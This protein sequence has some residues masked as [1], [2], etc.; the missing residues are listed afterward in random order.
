MPCLGKAGRNATVLLL[1]AVV[2]VVLRSARAIGESQ[3]DLGAAWP[4]PQGSVPGA[5]YRTDL[6]WKTSPDQST[7]RELSSARNVP[8]TGVID[9]QGVYYA[10]SQSEQGQSPYMY[11]VSL[12]GSGSQL[13]AEST[14]FRP[15]SNLVVSPVLSSEQGSSPKLLVVTASR[16]VSGASGL[17]D[18]T[19][20]YAL[21]TNATLTENT[22]RLYWSYPSA[23]SSSAVGDIRASGVPDE[24]GAIYFGVAEQD[25]T[26]VGYSGVSGVL[27]LSLATGLPAWSPP[28]IPI[29]AEG[30]SASPLVSG[31]NLLVRSGAWLYV[32]RRDSGAVIGSLDMVA[33]ASSGGLAECD[34]GTSTRKSDEL[35]SFGVADDVVMGLNKCV[36]SV[37]ISGSETGSLSI[38][39][40]RRF[41]EPIAGHIAVSYYGA[42]VAAEETGIVH[43]LDSATGKGL[44]GNSGIALS[45]PGSA[46]GSGATVVLSRGPLIIGDQSTLIVDKKNHFIWVLRHLD[47]SVKLEYPPAGAMTSEMVNVRDLPA[48]ARDGSLVFGSLEG[49]YSLGG[50]GGCAAGTSVVAGDPS[51]NICSVCPSGTYSNSLD[52]GTC[53][54]CSS[55]TWQSDERS[56]FCFIC[57]VPEWCEGGNVCA[58]ARTGTACSMCISGYFTLSD[59][60]RECPNGS[61]GYSLLFVVFCVGLVLLILRY[62]GAN[63]YVSGTKFTHELAP[64]DAVKLRVKIG[65]A[66]QTIERRVVRV[67]HDFHAILDEDVGLDVPVTGKRWKYRKKRKGGVSRWREGTGFM[68][69]PD[70]QGRLPKSTLMARAMKVFVYLVMGK[71]GHVLK[72]CRKGNADL[73]LM[74]KDHSAAL[75]DDSDSMGS[76]DSSDDENAPGDGGMKKR[77]IESATDSESEEEGPAAHADGPGVRAKREPCVKGTPTSGIQV[78]AT[79]LILGLTFFQTS[80]VVM[81]FDI[82]WPISISGFFPGIVFLSLPDLA[83]APE[84]SWSFSYAAKWFFSVT[85]PLLLLAGIYIGYCIYVER[86]PNPQVKRQLADRCVQTGLIIV[87][88]MFVFITAKS[89]EPLVCTRQADGRSYMDADPSVE[90][91]PF[92]G[93]YGLLSLAAAIFFIFWGIGTPVYLWRVLSKAKS[94]NRMGDINFIQRYGWLYLR[95]NR[96]YYWWELVVLARK[97]LLVLGAMITSYDPLVQSYLAL[98]IMFVFLGWH[99]HVRPYTCYECLKQ[100]K[101]RCRHWSA[102]DKLEG[103]MDFITILMLLFAVANE[104]SSGAHQDVIMIIMVVLIGIAIAA[105]SLTLL[106]AYVQGEKEQRALE[107]DGLATGTHKGVDMLLNLG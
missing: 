8:V 96:D 86:Y 97:L 40:A 21:L 42:Y 62:T 35:M 39:W 45:A 7:P 6:M 32:M 43:S 59:A 13:W 57:N 30:V 16:V 69:V 68:K 15:E 58:F 54:T 17:E 2:V 31:S 36:I 67:V 12:E 41:G 27:K 23:L 3:Y 88:I 10:G 55:G 9:A 48:V 11:A 105:I 46:E 92:Q 29:G 75:D 34:A 104:R 19:R 20:I 99:L 53:S 33:A 25:S 90:C 77:I 80:T 51:A 103:G 22:E 47:G 50:G 70:K 49:I 26:A 56:A 89:M 5:Q 94:Q 87:T 82:Q 76:L 65:G 1:V 61:F 102:N 107:E 14:I 85:F 60:C 63:S 24:D 106:R 91:T 100:R 79:A 95:Y 84:C 74:Q 93:A 18:D 83:L 4:S 28:T 81:Q 64:G 71:W 78:L 98:A 72:R 44:W 66:M 101:K 73:A 38:R 37:D 52:S